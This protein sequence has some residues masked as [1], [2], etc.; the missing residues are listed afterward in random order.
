MIAEGY[1]AQS[2]PCHFPTGG[3][4]TL[5]NGNPITINDAELFDDVTIVN[6]DVGKVIFTEGGLPIVVCGKG[7]L[8][9]TS[10]SD[11]TH[12]SILPLKKFRIRFGS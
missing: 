8:K 9:I 3:A 5:L 12:A 11:D 7:L 4:Q 10:A 6:R 1:C 2:M